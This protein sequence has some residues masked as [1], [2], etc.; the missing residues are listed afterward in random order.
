M[1]SPY[2][3]RA[4]V[5]ADLPLLSLWRSEEHVRRWWGAPDVEPE[6]EKLHEP[7]VA[8]WIA[9]RNG[10]PLAFIQDYLVLDW[11]PHHFE[12]L[13][14][15]SRGIDLYIGPSQELQ[16]GHGAAILR[17]HVEQLFARGVPAVG[18]DPNPENE[19]AQRSFAKAGFMIA[20]GPR[21]TRW[22][23]AVLMHRFAGVVPTAS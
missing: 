9:E 21:K 23:H 3:I 10:V 17:Q 4:A 15:G 20:G 12:Y 22:G 6:A 2:L 13:P 18:I 7:K 5:E 16:K 14:P 8:M 1:I 11:L 19:R